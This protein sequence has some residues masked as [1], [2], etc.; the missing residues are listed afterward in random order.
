MT[1]R[2]AAASVVGTSHLAVNAGCQDAYRCA[3][4]PSADN[5]P[6][7]AVVVSDGAGSA[8][9]GATGSAIVTTSLVEQ[10]TA[11]AASG[12][13]I[14]GLQHATVA[15]WLDGVR[16]TIAAEAGTANLPMRAYAATLL[17]ALADGRHAAFAQIGDGA[18]V[19]ADAGGDWGCEFWP[20]RG[21]FANQTFFVT[22]DEAHTNLRFAHSLQ[23]VMELAVFSDGLERVL[24]NMT[25][26]RAHAP[27]FDKM[28]N[29]L[30]STAGD[31]HIASLSDALQRYLETPAITS[32]TDD[33]VTL[34][35][36]T[37]LLPPLARS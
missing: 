10:M 26:H 16:E 34:V 6:I 31:S 12:G 24:L 4:L 27:A 33:D 36:A 9:Q 29:P 19:T 17:M 37:Q 20:Q 35:I 14:K 7:L 3:V 21:T 18:I 1:W 8:E 30:R 15:E 28:L 5:T 23:P 25:E 22:D 32:R 11:W 2:Y 13:T